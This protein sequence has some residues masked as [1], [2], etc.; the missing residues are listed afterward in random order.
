M[1]TRFQT[2]SKGRISLFSKLAK[3]KYRDEEGIF[4]AEGNK[5][6]MDTLGHFEP[7]NLVATQGWIDR[8]PSLAERHLPYLLL[9]S[10]KDMEKISQLSTAPDVIAIYK[11]PGWYGA[12]T[13][14]EP[15]KDE[16][17]L[18]LDGIQDPGNLGTIVRAANWFGVKRIYASRQTADILSAKA[19]MATMGA[20]SKVEI[21]YCDLQKLLKISEVPVFGTLLDGENI[22]AAE[23]TGTEGIIV[24]GN[25]GNGLSEEV[26]QLVTDRLYIPPYPADSADHPESLN[27]GVS[28]AIV[29]SEFR[30]RASKQ[31]LNSTAPQLHNPTTPQPLKQ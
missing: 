3:K 13:V 10:D 1:Q 21:C 11:Y 29:L 5:C 8:N 30:R 19:V 25:E 18:A 6:V 16:L 15:S 22:Y 7:V 28:A 9:A 12:E 17:Y 20:I 31:S 4:A 14:P 23:F 2:I 27:V 24:L 26:R